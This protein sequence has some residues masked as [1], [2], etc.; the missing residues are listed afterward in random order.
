MGFG[1]Q[2]ID[3]IYQGADARLSHEFSEDFGPSSFFRLRSTDQPTDDPWADNFDGDYLSNADEL[4]LFGTDPLRYDSSGDGV[5]DGYLLLGFVKREFWQQLEIPPF[6]SDVRN[7]LY[8]QGFPA[9]PTDQNFLQSL[10]TP[11][12]GEDSYGDRT[13]GFIV[14]SESKEY[15]ISIVGDDS[16]ELWLS[17]DAHRYNMRR[18]AYSDRSTGYDNWTKYESQS[19]E[20]IFLEAGVRY[21]FELLHL[22]RN[23]S[24][25]FRVAWQG[26][27]E[28]RQ[29]IASANLLS[30]IPD[31]TD[32]DDDGLLDAWE[33]ANGLDPTDGGSVNKKEGFFGDF[34]R[35]GLINSEE[36]AGGTDVLAFDSDSDGVG[37][38]FE[39]NYFQTS[40]TEPT[41][42]DPVGVSQ[43]WLSNDMDTH[44]KGA[45][46]EEAVGAETKLH[47]FA[48]CLNLNDRTTEQT[49]LFYK[50]VSGD[51][52]V[53]YSFDEAEQFVGY[54][55]QAKLAL[56][57]RES[58]APGARH[59][60]VVN[61][62][63]SLDR[64]ELFS[65]LAEGQPNVPGSHIILNHGK[66]KVWVRM[67]RNG[68]SF[69]AYLSVD[70]I[71][72]TQ[73]ATQSLDLPH[74]LYLGFSLHMSSP[75]AYGSAV[76]HVTEWKTD[77]DQ[78]G[79][80]D[81]DE[82]L[83][84]TSMTESDSDGDGYSDFE[85]INEFFTDPTVVDLGAETIAD[86]ATGS[87][88]IAQL[89]D[90]IV[91]GAVTYSRE[92]R[93][94]VEYEMTLPE[95]A[96]YRISLSGQSRF[97][98]TGTNLYNVKVSVDG[99]YIGRI[100][101]NDVENEAGAGRILSPWLKAGTHTLRFYVDNTYTHR[102]LQINEV[103]VG[104]VGGAD[105][106]QDTIPDWMTNRLAQLN[107]F[108]NATPEGVTQSPVSPFCLK[109]RSRYLDFSE[110]TDAQQLL[111][112]LPAFE[113]YT[114]VAL[115][116][117]ANTSVTFDFENQGLTQTAQIDWV[118]TNVA[119]TPAITI[120][121]GDALLLTAFEAATQPTDSVVIDLGDGS[122]AVTT[123]VDTPLEATFA[124]AGE[125]TINATVNGV[126]H[127][128]TVTVLEA[129]LGADLSL[130]RHS[131]YAFLPPALSVVAE[132]SADTA[133]L[134]EETTAPGDPRAFN[135]TAS[136]VESAILAARL[137]GDGAVLDHLTIDPF[138]LASNQ[139]ARIEVTDYYD[140]GAALVEVDFVLSDI[141]PDLRVVV[142]IFVGGITF[143]DG[144][145]EKVLTAADF[146]EVGR[147]TLKFI[148]PF[149]ATSSVCHR[150][151]IYSGD[152]F[153]GQQ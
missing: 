46:Y 28:E 40:P 13:R 102:S 143:E 29:I 8:L 104:Y 78:D 53:T 39:I 7:L 1:W 12:N 132:L 22:E 81:A 105:A 103:A 36:L 3:A 97:N 26:A 151:Y 61:P 68:N 137:P 23:N 131:A 2:Y 135:L 59:I 114:D 149:E 15:I 62:W 89:G 83:Y 91:D 124:Q 66:S 48:S 133:V 121:K 9:A 44:L 17:T 35:D 82:A 16:V 71:S 109:G 21:Y 76:A 140:D 60:T 42:F 87:E 95:D 67:V 49:S 45:I 84:G 69:T 153:L 37:D 6:T 19:S 5:G 152:E 141:P 136:D 30:W 110:S 64:Y 106:D 63:R 113:F 79:I 112:P 90:W 93:G 41:V 38:W 85:E 18:I 100:F 20:A 4:S 96:I 134:V 47:M 52:S 130:L 80:W 33:L 92:G 31:P 77:A 120:R 150:I 65:R 70:N 107:G 126:A 72:W 127:Q 74:S 10:E 99:V 148:M 142:R 139:E 27:G 14:S 55:K 51:F 138:S 25:Y 116:A 75:W 129:D 43:N 119:E 117:A 122:A 11:Q 50:T 34:D 147:T 108:D 58:L 54:A 111:S 32:A 123:T 57:A 56:M 24:D 146:D 98:Q 144:S 94:S 115:D 73:I 101:L 118:A 125:F 128:M 86:S 145:I 88:S